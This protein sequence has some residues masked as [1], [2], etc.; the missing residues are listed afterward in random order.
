MHYSNLYAVRPMKNLKDMLA[1]SVEIYGEKPA[2]FSK[3]SGSK[4]YQPISYNEFQDDVNSLGTALLDLGLDN[5]KI[6]VISENRYAWVI[7]YLAVL[8]GVGTIVPLDKELPESEIESLINRARASMVVYGNT[9][10]K[11]IK[12]IKNKIPGVKYFVHMDKSTDEEGVLSFSNLLQAGHKLLAEGNNAYLNRTID[13]EE[14]KILLFTSGTTAIS[15]AVMLSHRNITANLSAMSSMLY[16]APTDIFLSVLPIHHT[17]ECT[18]GLLCPVYRGAAVAFCEGLR[19]IPKNLKE[20]QATVMLGVPLIFES[21]YRI[22]WKQATKNPELLKKLKM[23]LKISNFLRK[24]NIDITKKLFKPIHENFGGKV[25]LFVNGAAAID[26]QVAEGFEELGIPVR[27]GYGLTECSPIVALNRDTPYRHDSAGLPLPNLEVKI[28]Q[29]NEE[30]VGEIIVKGPSVMHGYYENAEATAEALKDGWFYTGDLGKM[31]SEGF[32]FITG[33]KKN[34]IITKNGKNIYPEEIEILLGRSPY[35]AESMVYA[36]D[37]DTGGD[38]TTVAAQIVADKEALKE[39]YPGEELN[40][41]RVL[42]IIEQE[43]KKINQQLIAYKAIKKVIIREEE[44][45]K[46]TTRKI[47]R[48]IEEEQAGN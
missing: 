38:D 43:V 36:Y 5:K 7:T 23:G 46:T 29:P 21:I 11:Q 4:E 30:G 44:F 18:C 24:L 14:V 6:A 1:G 35:I 19:H 13:A 9:N 16:I 26:P 34:V 31:N 17:Y 10:E 15:K 40:Q 22:I 39:D 20:S 25:R 37:K 27:Q 33:R 45:A 32:V 3:M 12:N 48:Y 47:K 2:F 41:D 8:N 42:E 28:D